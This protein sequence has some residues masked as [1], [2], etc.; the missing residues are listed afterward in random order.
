MSTLG[1]RSAAL[2]TSLITKYGTDYAVY[3]SDIS[4]IG[5]FKAVEV[6][7][8]TLFA[9]TT[10]I[11]SASRVLFFLREFSVGELVYIDGG[12][13]FVQAVQK[14]QLQGNFIVSRVVLEK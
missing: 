3:S 1:E 13:K 6:D 11:E 2:A 5:S 10:L 12:K 4:L 8:L 14:K 9:P 7:L